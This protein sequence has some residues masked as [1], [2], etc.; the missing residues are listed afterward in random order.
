MTV[1]GCLPQDVLLPV[2]RAPEE[3]F[4]S[5]TV[6]GTG[7]SVDDRPVKDRSLVRVPLRERLIESS[8]RLAR[9]P[10]LPGKPELRERVEDWIWGT[11]EELGPDRG[12]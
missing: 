11:A 9:L 1:A 4:R 7:S 6:R 5:Q 8:E 10:I 3:I 12:R 2:C